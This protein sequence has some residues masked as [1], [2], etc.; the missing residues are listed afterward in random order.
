MSLA[1]L[2]QVQQFSDRQKIE[3]ID[4]I[5]ASM[6][7]AWD[8]APLVSWQQQKLAER[9]AADAERPDGVLGLEKFERRLRASM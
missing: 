9:L 2:P 1:E 6:E 8:D 4:E 3:L 7:S 5:W